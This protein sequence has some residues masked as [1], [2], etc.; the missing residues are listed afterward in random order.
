MRLAAVLPTGRKPRAVKTGGKSIRQII[1]DTMADKKVKNLDGLKE[2]IQD[3]TGKEPNKGTLNVQLSNLKKEGLI[4]SAGR[5]E[6][7]L[8]KIICL[9]VCSKDPR[10][11]VAGFLLLL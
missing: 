11:K 6:F 10:R 2:M 5:G 3:A 8:K 4:E 7:K 1:L 9:F